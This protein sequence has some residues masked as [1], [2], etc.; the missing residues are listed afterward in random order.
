MG[1]HEDIDHTGLTGVGGSV[2]TDAI[3]DAKGDL[4][5]GTGANTAAKL[6]VGANGS[7]L[8]AASGETTGLIWKKMVWGRV[9]ADGTAAAGSNFTSSKTAT[10]RYTVTF[11]SAFSTAPVAILTPYATAATQFIFLIAT[12]TTTTL[13]IDCTSFAGSDTDKAFSFLAIEP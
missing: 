1:D 12:P 10:G 3:F 8:A 5:G 2:A 6:T 7:V 4:A 9:N 11:D 13:S